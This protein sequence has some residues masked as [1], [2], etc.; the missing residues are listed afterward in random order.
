[1]KFQFGPKMALDFPERSAAICSKYLDRKRQKTRALDIGCAVG[2][3]S[4]QLSKYYDEVVGIDY[5]NHFIDA[6]NEMKE[7]GKMDFEILKQGNI[8][9]SCQTNLDQKIDRTKVTFLQGDACNLDKSIGKFDVIIG[10]IL[11]N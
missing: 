1:M 11:S 10:S 3:T 5:S 6:A 2:G 9:E 8:F 4:F 7:K